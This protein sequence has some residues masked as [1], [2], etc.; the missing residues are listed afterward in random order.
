MSLPA[1]IVTRKTLEALTGL[2]KTQVYK[3]TMER[4]LNFP[5]Q[6]GV[7]KP[8]IDYWDKNEVTRWL[9][10]NDVNKI[11]ISADK[12]NGKTSN[13]DNNLVRAFLTGKQ[14]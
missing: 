7:L 8:N 5:E 3:I 1:D 9:E 6:K 11:S 13:I 12:Y 2:S 10:N 4:S 14:P